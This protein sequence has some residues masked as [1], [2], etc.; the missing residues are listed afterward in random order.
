MKKTLLA[1]LATGLL[2]V[3]MTGAAGAITLPADPYGQL[4]NMYYSAKF[5]DSGEGTEIDW[6]KANLPNGVVL[7]DDCEFFKDESSD[8]SNEDQF[9]AKWVS[10]G[11]GNYAYDMSANPGGIFLIKTGKIDDV[12]ADHFLYQNLD[13]QDWA[14]INLGVLGITSLTNIAK[15]S[16]ISGLVC[17]PVPEPATMLLFGTGLAGLA[18]MVRRRKEK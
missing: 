11:N 13:S 6:M 18:G 4:D 5:D 9:Y 15:V 1:G 16:H 12:V 3:G 8:Y 2:V 17:T 7:G 14:V 10:L